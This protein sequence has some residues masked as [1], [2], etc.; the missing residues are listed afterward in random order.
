MVRVSPEY[1]SAHGGINNVTPGVGFANNN[2]GVSQPF[3]SGPSRGTYDNMQMDVEQN[4]TSMLDIA[5][6]DG[7]QGFGM[8]SNN[9][10]SLSTN[11]PPGRLNNYAL[12]PIAARNM[13]GPMGMVMG[14]AINMGMGMGRATGMGGIGGVAR[15]MNMNMNMGNTYT[16]TPAMT[17]AEALIIEQVNDSPNHHNIGSATTRMHAAHMNS[18]TCQATTVTRSTALVPSPPRA[19]DVSWVSCPKCAQPTPRKFPHCRLCGAPHGHL[20][21]G[22][23]L[24]GN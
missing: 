13:P 12:N 20:A 22:Y 17:S 6:N 2:L 5:I 1:I 18:P 15:N 14:N 19:N 10:N 9:W 7:G 4:E 8:G 16:H 24:N 23:A 3:M 21:V 11:V